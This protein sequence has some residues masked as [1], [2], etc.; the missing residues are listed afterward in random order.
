M[1]TFGDNRHALSRQGEARRENNEARCNHA[2]KP[3]TRH[4]R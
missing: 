2:S 4:P 1:L 3:A